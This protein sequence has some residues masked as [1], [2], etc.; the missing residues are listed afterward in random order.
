MSAT[1]LIVDDE[2]TLLSFLERILADEGYETLVATTLAQ[3]EQQLETRHVDILLLD[4]A[5]PDGDGL[6][7]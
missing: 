5:L 7:L 6:S 1:V 2:A 4:L 3:A